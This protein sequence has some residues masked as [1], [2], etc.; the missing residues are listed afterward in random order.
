LAPHI[1]DIAVNLGKYATFY[2]FLLLFAEK[3]D[4]GAKILSNLLIFFCGR[5]TP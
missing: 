4:G 1:S 2:T 3:N 5:Y